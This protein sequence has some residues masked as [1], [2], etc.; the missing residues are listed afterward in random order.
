MSADQHYGRQGKGWAK[1][2]PINVGEK[3]FNAAWS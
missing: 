3:Q 2:W 1:P